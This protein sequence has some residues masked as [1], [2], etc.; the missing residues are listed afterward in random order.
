MLQ[1]QQV[2]GLA[3]PSFLKFDAN[4]GKGMVEF[5]GTALSRDLGVLNL[6]VYA[7]ND[8]L[9]RIIIEVIPRR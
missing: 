9:A 6:G 7:D 2:S 8:C 1:V 3:L 5:T 4:G